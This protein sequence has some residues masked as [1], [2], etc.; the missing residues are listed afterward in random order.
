MSMIERSTHARTLTASGRG[1]WGLLLALVLVAG[2]ARVG[3]GGGRTMPIDPVLSAERPSRSVEV[4]AAQQLKRALAAQAAGDLGA[5]RTAATEI[6][7]RYPGAAVSGRALRLLTDIAYAQESWREADLHAQRWIRL[8]PE[9]DGRVPALRIVQGESRLRDG[10][11]GGALDRL[12]ALPADAP[13][14]VLQAALDIARRAGAMLDDGALVSRLAALP[15]A[16]PFAAPLHAARAR[17]LYNQGDDEGARRSADAA[18]TAGAAGVDGDVARAVLDR[19]VDEALGLIGPV[20]VI[21]VLLPKSGPP[22]LV[23]FAAEVEEGIRAATEAADWPGRISIVVHDDGGTAAGAAA[24]MR[25]LQEAGAAVVVGPLDSPELTAAAAARTT[26][27]PIVSPTAP[28]GIPGEANVYTLGGLDLEGA[29]ALARW[30]VASGLRRVALLYPRG[31][32]PELEVAAFEQTLREGGG[33]VLGK[34]A[35]RSGT[36]Y[37]ADEM[38]AIASLRPDALVLPISSADVETVAPQVTFFGLDTLDIRVLGTAGWTRDDVLSGV[39]PRHTDGVV[40]V[41]P[42][43][44]GAGDD[45]GMRALVGAYEGLY[46]R[47]LRS[48]VPAV[49]YD[50]AALLIEALRSGAR[51]PAAITAA[52]ERL[53]DFAGATGRLGVHDGQV[54]RLHRVVCVQARTLRPIRD[55]ERPILVDRRPRLLPGERAPAVEGT[56]VQVICPGVP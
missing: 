8:V 25:A 27:V 43:P 34:F 13:A 22:A 3:G 33:I 19:R 23:R 5:A 26:P 6:V 24:G 38:R 18:I 56:P 54:T 42:D 20:T 49:G 51:T 53:D 48:A 29:R 14:D 16:H 31:E 12:A 40:A 17:L 50:A 2:C 44:L 4:A 35:Y 41:T 32:E 15:A 55:G 1:I 11:P 37:F 28:E 36:T 7:D 39:S 10:D 30:A 45:A 47:T 46:R 52:L 9:G 21:G